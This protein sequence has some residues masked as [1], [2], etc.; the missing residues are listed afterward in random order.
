LGTIPI[1]NAHKNSLA[2]FIKQSD[3]SQRTVHSKKSCKNN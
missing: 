3:L 2:D 1:S